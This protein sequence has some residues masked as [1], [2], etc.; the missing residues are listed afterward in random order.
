MVTIREVN[1][2]AT[3]ALTLAGHGEGRGWIERLLQMMQEVM[4]ERD[5]ARYKIEALEIKIAELELLKM[6]N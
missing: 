1:A 3:R 4:L 2:A 6:T 5:A